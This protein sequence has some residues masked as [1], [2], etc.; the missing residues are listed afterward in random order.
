MVLGYL[1]AWAAF[2]AI[3]TTLQWLFEWLGLLSPMMMNSTN[4]L[5]SEGILLFA[6]VY[7]DKAGLPQA[8][9][10]ATVLALPLASRNWRG[11]QDGHPSRRILPWLC[12]GLMAILF[13][14]GVMNLYWMIGLAATVLIEKVFSFGP[15]LSAITGVFF[16]VWAMSFVYGAL[17]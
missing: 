14:G 2:S 1:L 12:R 11:A 10:R 3:A 16:I 9:S 6:G 4:A 17:A 8:L 15:K 13:F 7:A 5:F